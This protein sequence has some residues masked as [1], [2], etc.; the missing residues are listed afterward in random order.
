M[1]ARQLRA[2]SAGRGVA[3]NAYLTPEAQL[4]RGMAEHMEAVWE[5]DPTSGHILKAVL[6][7]GGQGGALDT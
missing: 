2:T 1:D 6:L 5:F 3:S 7:V 4:G